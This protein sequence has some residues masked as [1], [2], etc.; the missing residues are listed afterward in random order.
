M[1]HIVHYGLAGIRAKNQY[2]IRPI[3]DVDRED[4]EKYIER[5]KVK[6][7]IDKSN[8]DIYYTRNRVRNEIIPYLEEHVNK[9]IINTVDRLSKIIEVENDY[10]E[11]QEEKAYKDCLMELN[12]DKNLKLDLKKFNKYHKAIKNR[13][14]L[15]AI[16]DVLG[17][18]YNI[19][20]VHIDD[21]IKMLDNNIG[22]KYLM[23]NKNIKVYLK[24]GTVYVSKESK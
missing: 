12:Q 20:K 15:R 19:E 4:I 6:T 8:E 11:E 2:Y 22:N 10:L 13:I 9:N 18:S 16:K 17:S 23:P 21:I 5:I 1:I 24:Q 3:I 14:I 7:F